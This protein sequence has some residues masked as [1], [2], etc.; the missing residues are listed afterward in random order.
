MYDNCAGSTAWHEASGKSPRWL[1][2]YLRE[3]VHA[4]EAIAALSD[5]G[6]GYDWTCGT[7]ASIP[8]YFKRDEVRAA[9]HL[10]SPAEGSGS[11]FRYDSSGPASITLYPE[12]IKKIRVLI[13]NGDADSC[14]PY[15]GN[16]EWVA[17]L[18]KMGLASESKA[19][20]PW[21]ASA[22]N[23]VS[24]Y[25]TSYN[26]ADANLTQ[27]SFAFVTIK[28]SGHEAPHYAPEPSYAM[29]SRFLKGDAW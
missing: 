10:P 9:L 27:P 12:L 14:V 5:M 28:L 11:I 25:A 15:V 19:W 7:F 2:A 4:P 17:G 1:A 29:F 3:N 18:A 24:G 8:E 20:H 6:G 16:E 26:V 22:K 23:I 13:Y 21:Y